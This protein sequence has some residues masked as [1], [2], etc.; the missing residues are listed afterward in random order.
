MEVSIYVFVYA[1][2]ILVHQKLGGQNSG[3]FTSWDELERK[4]A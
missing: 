4:T 2:H 1:A 3:S